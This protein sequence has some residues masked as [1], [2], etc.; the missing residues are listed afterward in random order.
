MEDQEKV[1]PVI[2]EGTPLLPSFK[3]LQE[4]EEIGPKME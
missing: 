2:E 4:K 1:L 3:L